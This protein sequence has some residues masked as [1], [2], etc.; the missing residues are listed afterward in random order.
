VTIEVYRVVIVI[1]A[2]LRRRSNV[3]IVYQFCK[4]DAVMM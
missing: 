2:M 4:F 3:N 1:S